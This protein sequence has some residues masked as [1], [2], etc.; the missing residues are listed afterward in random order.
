VD[1]EVC[2]TEM[3]LKEIG[4]C[5]NWIHLAQDRDQWWTAV[6]TTMGIPVP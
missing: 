4:G 1:T 2:N 5:V 3:G 6:N